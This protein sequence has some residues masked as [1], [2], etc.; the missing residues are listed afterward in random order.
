M[1][2]KRA[3]RLECYAAI[4]KVMGDGIVHYY[5]NNPKQLDDAR[6]K[7]AIEASMQGLRRIL[8]VLDGY[9]ISFTEPLEESNPALR[10]LLKRLGLD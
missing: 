10:K 6:S 9:Q 5:R 4:R 3:A 1:P 8:A 7:A 2:E